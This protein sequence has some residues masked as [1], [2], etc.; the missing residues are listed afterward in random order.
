M[1]M[2]IDE[3]QGVIDVTQDP[4]NVNTSN[5]QANTQSN[6]EFNDDEATD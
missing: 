1:F 4:S 3:K 2:K 6:Q 5:E